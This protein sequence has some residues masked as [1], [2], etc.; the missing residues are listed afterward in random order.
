MRVAILWSQLS[1]YL[2]ACLK[3]LAGRE[4]VEICVFHQSAGGDAPF[5]EEQFGWMA[6][7]IAWRERPDTESLLDVLRTFKPDV[8]VVSGWSIAAYRR[9]AKAYRGKAVRVMT[10]DNPWEGTLKQRVGAFFS[11]IYVQPIADYAWG[12]GERQAAFA[13]RLGFAQ[14]RILRGVLSCDQPAFEQAYLRRMSSGESSSHS[15][16]YVGRFSHEKGLDVL[17]KAYDAYR[18]ISNA[19][20]PLRCCGDGPLRGL[21]E[22][23]PGIEVVGFIQPQELPGVMA[24]AGC[25]ILSSYYDH[26]SLAIH[27]A[28]SAGLPIIATEKAGAVA[29]LVQPGYNGFIFSDQDAGELAGFMARVASMD[30]EQLEAM[31]QASHALSLQF[32][33]QR[34]AETLLRVCTVTT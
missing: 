17:V 27:E 22:G 34:W 13:R 29:H 20:W 21:L 26:W 32:T 9:A 1:G 11:P 7:R 5:A 28:V 18:A 30:D 23:R 16:L 15:F 31:T 12:A 14:H 4:G 24:A 10:M 6:K 3:E 25:L 2:N 8:L 33:P 19:P